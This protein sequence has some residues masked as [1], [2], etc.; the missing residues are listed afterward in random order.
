MARSYEPSYGIVR[1]TIK[2]ETDKAI[3]VKLCSETHEEEGE[4]WFPL[5]QVRAGS[6]VRSKDVDGDVLEVATWL[7]DNKRIQY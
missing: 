3:L 1:G 5:S 6:I 7:L 4:Y 2:A